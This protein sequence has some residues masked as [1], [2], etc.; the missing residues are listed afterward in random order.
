MTHRRWTAFAVAAVTACAPA[1]APAPASV[2]VTPAPIAAPA[3]VATAS[4]AAAAPTARARFPSGLYAIRPSLERPSGIV[5]LVDPAAASLPRIEVFGVS[6]DVH[7][8]LIVGSTGRRTGVTLFFPDGTSRELPIAGLYRVNRPSLSPD[9]KQV[10][11]Q[12]TETIDPAADLGDTVFIVDL[13]T[14]A[15]RRIGDRPTSPSTQSEMPLWLPSGDRVAYWTTENNCLVIKIRDA[16]TA[17]DVVTIRKNGT[18]GCYQPQ[19]GILD[20]PRFHIAASADSSR[21]LI[22]GQMQV[23]DTKAGALVAD[24]H[25]RALDGLAAAGYKPDARFP[26]QAGAGTFPLS[27]TFSPDGTQIVFDGAVEKEGQFGAILCR[28]NVDGTGFTVLRPP[29]QVEPKFS[30]NHNFSQ[31]WPRWLASR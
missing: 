29:V 9:A 27:G 26:G 11:V 1:S 23:Y 7:P 18:S 16:A 13:A 21:L 2:A 24:V 12:A 28:I 14:G 25:Q 8:D 5:E 3:A 22:V 6:W 4:P 17:Q 10:F 19:R 15:F 20:G 31:L 30:N